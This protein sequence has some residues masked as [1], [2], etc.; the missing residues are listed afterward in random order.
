MDTL[1][2][3]QVAERIG[4]STSTLRYY[5]DIGLVAPASRSV[6][7]YRLYDRRSLERLAF[8]GHA[9]QLGCTLEEI[10][11]LLDIWDRDECAPVQR[12]FHELVTAKLAE[13]ET[14]I[15]ALRC[16]CLVEGAS[17]VGPVRSA[18]SPSLQRPESS[19][20]LRSTSERPG[21]GSS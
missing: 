7:G 2:I 15:A 6:S 21:R 18:G 9:K 1:T 13:T 20:A 4:F 8:V 19:A 12:R 14:T 5:E 3:G 11:D 10:T 16:V 17:P